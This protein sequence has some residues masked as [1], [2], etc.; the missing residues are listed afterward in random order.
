MLQKDHQ[1]RQVTTTTKKEH[2]AHLLFSS[3]TK[4]INLVATIFRSLTRVST[5]HRKV[6]QKLQRASKVAMAALFEASGFI[7]ST[8]I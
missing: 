6:R 7:I 4:P 2:Q 1:E 8:I 3:F 5:N